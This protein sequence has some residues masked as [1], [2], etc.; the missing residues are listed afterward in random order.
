MVLLFVF[1]LLGYVEC[2]DMV[3]CDLEL[4][5]IFMMVVV[6]NVVEGFLNNV[7]CL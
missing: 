5:V 6:K 4:V 3:F 7:L 1:E 2:F